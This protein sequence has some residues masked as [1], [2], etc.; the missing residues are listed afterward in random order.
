MAPAVLYRDGRIAMKKPRFTEQQITGGPCVLPMTV[1]C[2]SFAKIQSGGKWFA[3][4]R[5]V[6]GARRGFRGRA[7]GGRRK[8]RAEGEVNDTDARLRR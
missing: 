2:L 5:R 4:R 6:A 8:E 3:C 1:S 7:G